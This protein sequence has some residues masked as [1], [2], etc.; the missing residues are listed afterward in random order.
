MAA[1]GGWQSG[2][3]GWVAGGAGGGVFES[4]AEMAAADGDQ[5]MFVNGGGSFTQTLSGVP[6]ENDRRYILMAEVGNRG[7]VVPFAGYQL[8][9]LAGGT[10]IAMDDNS[11]GVPGTGLFYTTSVI[12][13]RTFSDHPLAGQDLG[14]RLTALGSN[15]PTVYNHTYF[16]NIRLFSVAVPE[17]STLALALL[18]LVGLAGYGSRR[19]RNR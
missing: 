16:D 9:L 13:F 12:D 6:L 11:L 14:I 19:R 7:G 5:V 1:G 4:A 10:T 3:T 17:P 8:E 18:G 15:G 2:A